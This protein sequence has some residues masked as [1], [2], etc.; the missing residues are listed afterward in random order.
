[1]T[2]G[3]SITGM[4]GSYNSSSS[5][6]F[7]AVELSIPFVRKAI[8]VLQIE[9]PIFPII[10]ADFGC[11]HGANSIYIIKIII[12]LIKQ[13]KDIQSPLLVIHND[14]PSNDWRTVFD[15]LNTDDSYCGLSSGR[16]FYKQ[17]LPSNFVTMSYCSTSIHW[18][19]RK[20]CQII[21][22]C[23]SV[24]AQPEQF[25]RFIAQAKD[26]YEQFLIHR[27][28][29]LRTGG[30]FILT[31]LSADENRR[32]PID[33]PIDQL[34]QCA[35]EMSLTE[36]ELLDYTIPL[37]F[38]TFDECVNEEL[39]KRCSLQLIQSGFSKAKSKFYQDFQEGNITVE[40]LAQFHTNFQR[41]WS[42][43]ALREMLQSNGQRTKE[44]IEQFLHQFWSL[45]KE[46]MKETPT[47]CNSDLYQ[48]FLVLKKLL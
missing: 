33:Y 10:I 34:Y 43:S 45:Y 35:K 22:H 26:D 40:E 36:E 23:G 44:D 25:D 16:S 20:P 14:L 1:M 27:S 29:E 21:D 31:V 39:F 48:T 7:N 9:S 19:S 6:Q 13:T 8:E 15:L 24:Y 30:V 2:E 3:S 42:E 46:K 18:L 5:T 11:S 41:S 12:D 4:A 17:C 38:R 37:Y 47:E 28:R 32:T